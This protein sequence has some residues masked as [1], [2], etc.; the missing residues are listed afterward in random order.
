VCFIGPLSTSQKS[1]TLL[2]YARDVQYLMN[3]LGHQRY[4]IVGA[5]GGAPYALAMTYLAGLAGSADDARGTLLITPTTPPEAQEL[6]FQVSTLPV[7]F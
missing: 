4:G 1:Y 3:H 6:S 5:C 2:D 7:P